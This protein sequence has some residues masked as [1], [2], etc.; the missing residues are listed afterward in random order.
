M[1]KNKNVMRLSGCALG[2]AFG[3]T[4]GLGMFLLALCNI[5]GNL[6][7]PLL[8]ILGSVYVGFAGTLKGAV[9]GLLWGL[10]EGFIFGVL[11]AVIYNFILNHCSCRS[12]KSCCNNKCE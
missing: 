3:I 12:C 4:W 10:L 5:N 9:I 1:E 6:G 8:S 2:V 7:A 11:V